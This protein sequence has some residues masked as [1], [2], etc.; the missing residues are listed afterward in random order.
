MKIN[1][2]HYFTYSTNVLAL[3]TQFEGGVQHQIYVGSRQYAVTC[4]CLCFLTYQE[5]CLFNRTLQDPAEEIYHMLAVSWT[6]LRL[7]AG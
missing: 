5:I 4:L 1:V 2:N 7:L 6:T 3:C